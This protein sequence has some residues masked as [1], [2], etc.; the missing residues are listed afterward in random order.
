MSVQIGHLLP[1]GKT[2]YVAGA[3]R[4]SFAGQ[5]LLFEMTSSSSS[6]E[7]GGRVSSALSA[8]PSQYLTGEQF[9]S[10][11]GH[12]VAVADLNSDG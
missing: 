7:G 8:D 3:P 6:S 9:G 1:G 5:V 10:G 11:F 4:S 2:T 12:S